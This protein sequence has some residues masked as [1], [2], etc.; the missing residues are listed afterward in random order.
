MTDDAS[1]PEFDRRARRVERG[2]IAVLQVIM[3]V[4]L[5]FAL[6]GGH[7]LTA[8]LVVAVMA[9]T[10]GPL[11]L[12]DRI[13]IRIP[14]QL[15]LL[16]VLFVFAS[17]FLGE[18]RSYY[19]R[20]WWWDLLLHG[21]SGLLLG[22]VGFLLV[23]VL[24]ESERIGLQMRPRFVAIFAFVFAVAIGALWEVFEFAMDQLFG[25]T[26]Q[27]PMLGDPSGLTDTMW[28]LIVD[29]FGAAVVSAFGWWQMKRRRRSFLERWIEDFV[30]RNPRLFKS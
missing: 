17:L 15:E 10:A 9:L 14:T 22:I 20:Y 11:L 30:R 2:V 27:K 5:G 29:A 3:A 13:P 7:W 12:R 23:Y 19:E 1:R 6:Y 4:E 16:A 18:V 21:C 8:S 28:D 25:T 26:M 24:N